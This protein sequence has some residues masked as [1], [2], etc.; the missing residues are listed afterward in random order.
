M[1]TINYVQNDQRPP[2]RVRLHNGKI[3]D[4]ATPIDVSY[5]GVTVRAHVKFNGVLKESLVGQKMSGH[6]LS[7]DRRT[8]IWEIDTNAPYNVP[9][10]GGIVVFPPSATT[11]DTPG[12]YEVEY[13]IDYGSGVTQTVFKTDIVNVREQFA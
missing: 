3:A 10:I 7:V 6:L 9:G 2:L 5:S 13:E 4:G 11:F 1:S 12:T 8:G